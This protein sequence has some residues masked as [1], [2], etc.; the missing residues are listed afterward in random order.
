MKDI[1]PEEIN[2]KNFNS[3]DYIYILIIV[4]TI[5]SSFILA[6]LIYKMFAG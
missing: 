5:L 6:I 3:V 2:S 1:Y 4:S